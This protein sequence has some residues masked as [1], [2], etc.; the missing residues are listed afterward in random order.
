MGYMV[1]LN[2]TWLRGR[3][4]RSQ[5][6]W[7]VII[8]ELIAGEDELAD[9]RSRVS[10]IDSELSEDGKCQGRSDE[11]NALRRTKKN[12]ETQDSFEGI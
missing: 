12:D 9:R 10:E 1:E 5:D 4:R 8:R 7:N 11:Y 2:Q 6:G 3:T